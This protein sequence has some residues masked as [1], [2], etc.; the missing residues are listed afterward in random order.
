MGQSHD[1]RFELDEPRCSSVYRTLLGTRKITSAPPGTSRSLI[2]VFRQF[3][4]SS[5]DLLTQTNESAPRRVFASG[6][7]SHIFV[8]LVRASAQ[9]YRSQP[10]HIH[11]AESK[12]ASRRISRLWETQW[13]RA[14]SGGVYATV[15]VLR[16][17]GVLSIKL[18]RRTS[19]R[20]LC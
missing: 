9:P 19:C 16:F 5:A 6:R 18:S 2:E 4:V 3:W 20:N 15:V 13:P 14:A 1:G 11:G 10:P 12:N 17:S 7:L 8:D